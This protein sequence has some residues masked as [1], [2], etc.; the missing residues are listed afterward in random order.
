M[1][2]EK[3]KVRELRILVENGAIKDVNVIAAG[4]EFYITF[5]GGRLILQTDRREI[6][7]FV[8]TL[9]VFEFLHSLGIGY[10]SV[11]LSRWAP[12]QKRLNH[13]EQK[14]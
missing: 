11:D 4:A 3:I 13:Q 9:T 7:F 6:R 1:E 5:N 14:E 10:F 12:E 2:Q 8:K